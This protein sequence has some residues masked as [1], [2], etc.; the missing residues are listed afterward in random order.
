MQES[1]TAGKRATHLPA[2]ICEMLEQR[3]LLLR[4]GHTYSK[5]HVLEGSKETHS[6]EQRREQIEDKTIQSRSAR[7]ERETPKELPLRGQEG[8]EAA[9]ARFLGFPR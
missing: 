9:G 7:G 2:V 8:Q 3:K 5:L 4:C 1:T 6:N